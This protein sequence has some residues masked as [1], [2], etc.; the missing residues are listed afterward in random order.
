MKK[1]RFQMIRQMVDVFKMTIELRPQFRVYALIAI[2]LPL[3]VSVTAMIITGLYI[4]FAPLTVLIPL[5]AFMITLSRNA[6]AAG[7]ARIHGQAGASGA[8]LNNLKLGYTQFDEQPVAV[9]AKT[10]DLIFR[11]TSRAG[12]LLVTEGPT[13]RV[14][15]L[16]EK[17]VQKLKRLVPNVP[18]H[19]INCGD[20]V[21]QVPLSKLRSAVMKPKATLKKAEVAQI[22][23]RLNALGAM[24]LP[25][26]KGMD[27][28]RVKSVNRRALRGK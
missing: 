14:K 1:K 4:V 16:V 13:G 7:Y 26:P 10:Q 3:V 6:E 19:I 9:D 17:E 11:G 23:K 2:L 20:D 18:I 22:R 15:K 21:G 8:I 28:N 25:I 12:I 5:I 27:P 24:K